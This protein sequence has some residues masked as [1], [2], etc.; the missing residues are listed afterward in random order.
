[1]YISSLYIWME[2]VELFT[3]VSYGKGKI[4]YHIRVDLHLFTVLRNHN[5][6]VRKVSLLDLEILHLGSD[7]VAIFF[8][9]DVVDHTLM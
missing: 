4:N 8:L 6:L 1:M 3:S 7:I 5:H 9:I 2:L